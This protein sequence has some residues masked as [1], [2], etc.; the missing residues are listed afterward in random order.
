MKRLEE[1]ME[2]EGNNDGID[3]DLRSLFP[4]KIRYLDL[5]CLELQNLPTRLPLPMLIRDEYDI[6]TST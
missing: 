1:K 4:V 6:I 3:D 5:S 2:A